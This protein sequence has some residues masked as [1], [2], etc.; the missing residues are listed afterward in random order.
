MRFSH[1]FFPKGAVLIVLRHPSHY[2]IITIL[3]ADNLRVKL[4]LNHWINLALL[5]RGGTSPH[6]SN[7]TFIL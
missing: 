3:P 5:S 6:Y 7:S 2:F 4:R 1:V